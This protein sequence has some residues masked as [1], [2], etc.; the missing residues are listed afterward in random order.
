MPHSSHDS[1]IKDLQVSNSSREWSFGISTSTPYPQP[2]RCSV[3]SR[4]CS[5]SSP[6]CSVFVQ[7]RE[8]SKLLV[9]PSR[10]LHCSV[11]YDSKVSGIAT[12][13]CFLLADELVVTRAWAAKE[14]SKIQKLPCVYIG[15]AIT[16]NGNI[17]ITSTPFYCPLLRRSRDLL[18]EVHS[19]PRSLLFQLED[20]LPL[21]LGCDE[22]GTV[23]MKVSI[24][25]T[26][27]F[28]LAEM[29]LKAI[30]ALIY[31]IPDLE[32]SP[33]C[34]FAFPVTRCRSSRN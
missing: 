5:G 10:R 22:S 25:T 8:T 9:L 23:N 3:H 6:C 33:P 32:S 31:E 11:H 2:V 29:S 7:E 12:D 28:F 14:A 24:R 27:T 34:A 1:S 16:S 13:R 19:F 17:L 26:C 20:S 30:L 18:N 4:I 15:S 21:P